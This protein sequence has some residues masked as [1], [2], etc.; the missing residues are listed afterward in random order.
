MRGRAFGRFMGG[1]A[2]VG[3][4][5]LLAQAAPSFAHNGDDDGP[6]LKGNYEKGSLR[7]DLN[8]GAAVPIELTV[9]DTPNPNGSVELKL[10]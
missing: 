1:C 7:L 2:A 10:D 4:A 8:R 5:A 3:C 6:R 9:I